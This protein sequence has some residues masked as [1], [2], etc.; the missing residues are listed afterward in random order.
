MGKQAGSLSLPKL[1]P[2]IFTTIGLCSGLTGI[3]FALESQWESAVFLILVAAC[4]DMID[5]LSARLLKAFS[6]F[7]AELD[8]LADTIS[9]GV[10]PA[11]I[12]YLWIREPIVELQKQHLLEWYWIPFLLFAACN[13]FRLARFNVMHLGESETKTTKSYFI[14]VPAPAAAG[15]VLMPLGVDFILDRFGEKAFLENYPIWVIGWVTVISLLMISRIPTFSFRNVRFNVAR[16]RA[17]IVLLVVLLSVAVF[18]K[19]KWIFLFSLGVLYFVSIPFSYWS[20]SADSI[21]DVLDTPDDP[22]SAEDS[23]ADT[24]SDT[25]ESG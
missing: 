16:N 4:F 3:R 17:L 6:P 25:E 7:G 1:L 12:T 11:I 2:N 23:V 10:A 14:G 21:V 24:S 8:S 22:V 9:F 15:L 20:H 13:A 19:E 5:G 18:M